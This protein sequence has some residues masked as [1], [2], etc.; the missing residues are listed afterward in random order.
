MSELGSGGHTCGCPG[1]TFPALTHSP[2]TPP[3]HPPTTLITEEELDALRPRWRD[4]LSARLGLPPLSQ[5]LRAAAPGLGGA[6][7]VV[8][9]STSDASSSSSS[10]GLADGLALASGVG[11]RSG[12]W[13]A[14]ADAPTLSLL[15]A[16]L[17]VLRGG[18]HDL[19]ADL[20][21]APAADLA[22]T[23]APLPHS[24]SAAALQATPPPHP[25]EVAAA[26]LA[27][28]VARGEGTHAT[29]GASAAL[30]AAAS[31]SAERARH[32]RELLLDPRQGAH[33]QPPPPWQPD[34]A[35]A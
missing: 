21:A 26:S 28:A 32:M 31:Y 15:H 11:S 18:V 5:R 8:A 16:K 29:S 4:R 34:Y 3:P 13:S 19:A 2:S 25:L 6:T 1:A 27:A 22:P 10:G 30:A 24:T 7:G 23:A 17:R 35:A 12:S 14:Q 20:R 33:Q 9:S